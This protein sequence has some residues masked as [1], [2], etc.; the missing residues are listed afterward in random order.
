MVKPSREEIPKTLNHDRM[1]ALLESRG[2]VATIGGKHS[3]K[4]EKDGERPITVPRHR[5]RDYSKDLAHRILRQAGL[6]GAE[7][8]ADTNRDTASEE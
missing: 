5:G 8:D 6:K 7:S 4:M 3:T 2:W 1:K